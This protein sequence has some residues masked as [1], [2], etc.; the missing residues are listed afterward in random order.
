MLLT[1]LHRLLVF[2]SHDYV[3]LTYFNETHTCTYFDSV[4]AK[5]VKQL[6]HNFSVEHNY[7]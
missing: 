6:E 2:E 7:G 1:E 5:Q 4:K 3:S